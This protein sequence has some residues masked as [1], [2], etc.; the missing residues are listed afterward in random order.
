MPKPS[1][2]PARRPVIVEYLRDLGL[3]DA[4]AEDQLAALREAGYRDVTAGHLYVAMSAE[5]KKT[6]RTASGK[7]PR[8]KKPSEKPLVPAFAPRPWSA[9]GR[10]KPVKRAPSRERATSQ[11]APGLRGRKPS[12]NSI[13]LKTLSSE[14]R[15][16]VQQA[17]ALGP[18][19]ASRVMKGIERLFENLFRATG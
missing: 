18:D 1:A 7:K 19:R 10:A 3:M 14:E 15:A 9:R 4:P 12:V 6:S 17:L 13:V 2:S 11:A 16:L 8:E 5:K